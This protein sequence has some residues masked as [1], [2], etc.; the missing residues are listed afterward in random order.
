MLENTNSLIANSKQ[1]SDLTF[2]NF[3]DIVVMLEEKYPDFYQNIR[4]TAINVY[5]VSFIVPA[6]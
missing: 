4:D 1:S 2:E 5:G 3:L 6:R